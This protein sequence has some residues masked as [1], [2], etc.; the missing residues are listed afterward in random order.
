MTWSEGCIEGGRG[1]KD[2]PDDRSLQCL[3]DEAGHM[4]HNDEMCNQVSRQNAQ[5]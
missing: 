5:E 4:A 2:V 1:K 3:S